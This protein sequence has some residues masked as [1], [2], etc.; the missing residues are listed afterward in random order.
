MKLG[1]STYTLTWSVGVPGY[2]RPL[3]PLS[4]VALVL[5]TR[6]RGLELLQIAD[7]LPL[8]A[9]NDEELRELKRTADGQGVELEV[10]TRGT[11]PHLLLRYLAIAELLGSSL[12]RTLITTSDLA[13]AEAQIREA[14]PAF[15]AANVMLAIENHGL[16]TTGQLVQLFQNLNHAHV[17]CCMDTVN[18]FGA[19]EAPDTV[20]A[21]LSPYLVNLHIKDF[22][23]R[24]VDHMMGFTI[25]GT[26]AGAG[27]L[28]IPRLKAVIEAN[29]KAGVNA[30]L[31]LWTPYEGSV[32]ET[33]ATETRWME[34][35]IAYLRSVHFIEEDLRY[36]TGNVERESI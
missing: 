6:S 21:A 7:N 18:S 8:H 20:I 22:D 1:L 24:R 30:I 12:V 32:E 29:G 35:S 15:E 19:L 16:H 27:R 14:L 9:M 25:L 34:E 2:E 10:G 3:Q 11:D 23:I 33:I 28:D 31:E 26:P 36:A 4:A 5:L 13:A 17:G